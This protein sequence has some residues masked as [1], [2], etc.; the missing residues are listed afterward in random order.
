MLCDLFLRACFVQG[1][2]FLLVVWIKLGI[3]DGALLKTNPFY[4]FVEEDRKER[5]LSTKLYCC[6]GDKQGKRNAADVCEIL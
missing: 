2:H 5:Q 1:A 6:R 4:R 3:D